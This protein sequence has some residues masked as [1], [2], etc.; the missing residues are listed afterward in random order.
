[1][2]GLGTAIARLSRSAQVAVLCAVALVLAI[3]AGVIGGIAAALTI[4]LGAAVV[5]GAVYG[6]RNFLSRRDER[7]A[8]P[9][10][11]LLASSAAG[12]T[13][14]AEPARRAR[15]DELRKSF[16]TGLEKFR[17]AGKSL[18]SVPWYVLIGEPGSGKT[19]AV[20]HCGV[21]FPP[22]LQD[23][24]Q[25]AGGTLNMSWWF[26]NQ[27]VILDTAGR[28]LFED[29]EPGSTS[30][31]Q[32]F[33]KL[34]KKS[35]PNCPVNGLLV[36]IPADSLI[37]DSDEVIDS[38]AV[39]LAG[40]LDTIQKLLGV[41]FPAYVVV[42]KSDLVNGFR[43]FFDRTDDPRAAN[44]ILGW[45]NPDPLDKPFRPE[46]VDEHLR[47]VENRLVRRRL[48]LL[49]DPVNTDD[50]R[51]SRLDQVDALYAFPESL[52][53]VGPRLRRYL[54][55]MFVAGE[56][57][58]RPLFLR[59]IYF[60]SALREGAALDADLAAAL[61]VSPDK[62][63]DGKIWERERA[64]F[65]KDLFLNKVFREKGLVTRAADTASLLR[66]RAAMLLGACGIGLVVI[67][68]LTW[69][70]ARGLQ[71]AAVEPA[72]FWSSVAAAVE[73]GKAPSVEPG[74]PPYRLPIISKAI[75]SDEDF[76]YRGD[77]GADASLLRGL[78][79]EQDARRIGAVHTVLAERASQRISVPIVFYP[80]A[81]I[82]GDVS[83]SLLA[84]SRLAAA[85]AAFEAGVL[86]P[87][88]EAAVSRL[89][90]DAA[91][92]R[93]W[94]AESTAALEQLIRTEAARSGSADSAT[95]IQLDPLLKFALTGNDSYLLEGAAED[96]RELQ[97]LADT[98]YAGD[99]RANWPPA[100][101]AID[102]S[103][104]VSRSVERF[105]AAVDAATQS[106]AGPAGRLMIALEAFAEA[107]QALL[108]QLSPQP[109]V[110]SERWLSQVDSLRSAA[111]QASSLLPSLSGRR[112]EQ[113]AIQDAASEASRLRDDAHRILDLLSTAAARSPALAHCSQTLKA[114]TDAAAARRV[115]L[116]AIST[117]AAKLAEDHLGRGL[118]PLFA[119]RF[120][121]Y[122]S[123]AALAESVD[124]PVP[125]LAI[126]EAAPLLSELDQAASEVR[127]AA[128]SALR[129]PDAGDNDPRYRACI[130]AVEASVAARRSAIAGA[131]SKTAT[132]DE[133]TLLNAAL[134][135]ADDLAD[136]LPVFSLPLARAEA[137]VD[138]AF[139]PRVAAPLIGEILT[140]SG[141]A[142]Q[143]S[144]VARLRIAAAGGFVQSYTSAW[145][146]GLAD[147]IAPVAQP[148]WQEF[149]RAIAQLAGAAS[150]RESLAPAAEAQFRAA[151]ALMGM[152][153]VGEARQAA[154]RSSRIAAAS[155]AAVANLAV[156]SAYERV[157]NNWKSLGADRDAARR[158]LIAA[159]SAPSASGGQDYF[160]IP[161]GDPRETDLVAR[162][163]RSFSLAALRTLTRDARAEA[164]APGPF[165]RF[166]LAKY[167]AATGQL[168]PA[169]VLEARASGNPAGP[170]TASIADGVRDAEI[171]A[172]LRTLQS[173]GAGGGASGLN[174]AMLGVLPDRAEQRFA[175][176]AELHPGP[177]GGVAFAA[178]RL[179]QLGTET[180]TIAAAPAAFTSLGRIDY[181]GASVQI[182][183]LAQNTPDAQPVATA[184]IPGP[185]LGL[186]LIAAYQG[187]PVV[188]ADRRRWEVKLPVET[189]TGPREMRLRMSFDDRELPDP[190]LWPR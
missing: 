30:E 186:W 148:S 94:T 104:F 150:I 67:G 114:A 91:A 6:Y 116:D 10:A 126:G 187:Q 185:W 160:A 183:F 22:G 71:Q 108:D 139:D 26:T 33:L 144:P 5:G 38:K 141:A 65:L 25:G 16:E 82:A 28:L 110:A 51:K 172:E 69:L 61:N 171:A 123:L 124:E 29:V 99:A 169:Q 70:G 81:V 50:A 95:S 64:L 181:P 44:Q 98:Y 87:L 166:P 23:E 179:R 60:T 102:R 13:R 74:R 77:D 170:G 83:G 163:W 76:R 34:L 100:S 85:R 149:Q 122:E 190:A 152:P 180:R 145:T 9:F 119:A 43:E 167:D 117:R 120:K 97:R 156:D 115:N 93:P 138:A 35:R 103:A 168:T 8:S 36:V 52:S 146:D 137:S 14:I 125:A 89:E 109:G 11:D 21:G 135:L 12:P 173:V 78:A 128:R 113:A 157:L 188:A 127:G 86:R 142:P 88:T 59:G 40:Q 68:L 37:K 7:Q 174:A 118:E 66:A 63:P 101:V 175:C 129:S 39:R 31:W 189:S 1:M 17:S 55:R 164:P 105:A 111:G 62:L 130:A 92:E 3:V 49:I 80:A 54:E 154:E 134:R 159:L 2:S 32:E 161:L 19:E 48:G 153:L 176:T 131:Y 143:S 41:R 58:A 121:V 182:E 90:A 75:V 18:Y 84:E 42:T 106:A 158:A 112:L 53:R 27:A 24:L 162:W 132:V 133:A 46:L 177:D 20:R 72:Q 73:A 79:V 140:V 151:S 155:K 165:A 4:L 147:V 15:L 107:E 184:S 96:A 56:W 136:P 45:S 57:S 47:S 178:I